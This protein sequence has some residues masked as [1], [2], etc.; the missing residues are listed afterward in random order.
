MEDEYLYTNV[1][2]ADDV[3][4]FLA[5]GVG[6]MMFERAKAER[7]LAFA[8]FEKLSPEDPNFNNKV[9][10]VQQRAAIPRWFV[11]WVGDTIRTGDAAERELRSRDPRTTEH[12]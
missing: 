6:K 2:N 5:N 8:E 11:K 4:R 7:L 1:S 10:E 3:R 12:A 9:R